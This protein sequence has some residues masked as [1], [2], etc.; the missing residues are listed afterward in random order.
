MQA[1]AVGVASLSIHYFVHRRAAV[2]LERRTTSSCGVTD[3]GKGIDIGNSESDGSVVG[4]AGE[5]EEERVELGFQK[6]EG[7]STSTA[8]TSPMVHG[9]VGLE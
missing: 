5:E 7:K 8:V 4:N 9:G 2:V 6:E 3:G 1:A